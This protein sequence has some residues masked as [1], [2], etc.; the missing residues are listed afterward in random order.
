MS[1]EPTEKDAE[2]RRLHSE[3][4]AREREIRDLG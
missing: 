3:A 1:R 4:D 2:L